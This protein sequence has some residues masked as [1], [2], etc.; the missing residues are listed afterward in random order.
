M[1]YI[2][3]ILGL[4]APAAWSAEIQ[5]EGYYRLELDSKPIGYVIQRFETEPKQK[6]MRYAYFLKTNE[7]GGDI[8]ESLKAEA[9]TKEKAEFEPITYHYTGQ[10]GKDLKSIDGAFKNDKMEIEKT[11]G[12]TVKKELYKIPQ[13]TFLSSFLPY[14]MLQSGIKAGKKFTY[15][16]VAEEEGNSYKGEAVVKGEEKFAGQN[17]FRIENVFMGKKFV[18]FMTAQGEVLGTISPSSKLMLVLVTNPT[19]ATQGFP[20]PN[21]SI[22]L[23]FGNIPTGKTNVLANAKPAPAEGGKPAPKSAPAEGIDTGD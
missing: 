5:F 6:I 16:A 21:K 10:T 22:M 1:V 23:T 15:S 14:F 4:L 9:K 13:G 7:T 18:S 2:C 3:L 17:V 19:D 20:V 8:Q 11:D 12:K